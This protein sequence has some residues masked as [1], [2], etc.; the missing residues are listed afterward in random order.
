MLLAFAVLAPAA[1]AAQV[2]QTLSE[3]LAE[4]ERVPVI[5]TF[6]LPVFEADGP[7]AMTDAVIDA[8]ISQQRD[9][10]ERAIGVPAETLAAPTAQ[11]ARLRREFRS[12]A[13]VSMY[14]TAGE[15]DALLADPSVSDVQLDQVVP[16][17]TNGTIP[18]IGASTLHTGG[19]TGSG[20]T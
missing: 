11:A 12:V 1:F 18:L 8:R 20:A 15:I 9:I 7:A 5:V 4:S 17:T 6:D 14:L 16:P 19:L 3:A 13:M 2:D 10:I